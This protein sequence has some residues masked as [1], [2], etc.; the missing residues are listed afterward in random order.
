MPFWDKLESSWSHTGEDYKIGVG[1]DKSHQYMETKNAVI[2]VATDP[3]TK[4]VVAFKPFIQSFTIDYDMKFHEKKEVW[5]GKT[6]LA[7]I[8]AACIY[9]LKIKMPATSINEARLNKRKLELFRNFVTSDFMD[10]DGNTKALY[11]PKRHLFYF[12]NL[13][14]GGSTKSLNTAGDGD[15]SYESLFDVALQGVFKEINYSVVVE[16]GFFEY[17]GKLF[18][19][20]YDCTFSFIVFNEQVKFD[21]N[22]SHHLCDG[23]VDDSGN[24][25][26]DLRPSDD[27]AGGWPFGITINNKKATSRTPKIDNFSY[28]LL[29]KAVNG[30]GA[31]REYSN[32]KNANIYIFPRASYTNFITDTRR[33][34]SFKPFVQSVSF[35]RAFSK[36]EV[37]DSHYRTSFYGFPASDAE[38]TLDFDVVCHS[39]ND[40]I[41]SHAKLQELFKFIAPTT[42]KSSIETSGAEQ[43]K[44]EFEERTST[45][46]VGVLFSNIIF[47]ELLLRDSENPL[48][49]NS[50]IDPLEDWTSAGL[51]GDQYGNY[52]M[53]ARPFWLT[54]VTYSPDVGL[55]FF[56]YDG[57]LFAKSFK[58]SLSLRENYSTNA[59][60]A[61]YALTRPTS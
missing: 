36:E 48:L 17:D 10:N 61:I 57:K 31:E 9:N 42:E 56:E 16:D 24:T 52:K 12:N 27:K 28:E 49:V 18:P 40:A 35:K 38:F 50:G 33:C 46:W 55:G 23:Y 26:L 53:A 39:I 15:A 21:G 22:R 34:L 14:S 25:G 5:T 1:S 3:D 13:I 32:Q 7:P 47:N 30:E 41:A 20:N 59:K 37:F 58:I 44:G 60:K 4:R 29:Y 2:Y 8:K 19:K 11:T 54:K 45:N 43:F 51:D 6:F